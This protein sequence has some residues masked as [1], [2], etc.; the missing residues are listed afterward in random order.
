MFAVFIDFLQ[1]MFFLAFVALQF[2][3]PVG[4]GVG[5]ALAAGY[6]CW[7]MSTGILSGIS[8]AAA[9]A[10]AGG[11]VGAG[12]SAFAIPLGTA[13]DVVISFVFGGALILL[14]IFNRMYYPMP[15]V[16]GFIMESIPVFNII[17][18]WTLMTLRCIALKRREEKKMA[19]PAPATVEVISTP[20][21]FDGI[22]A[23]NDN[24]YEAKV[25]A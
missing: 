16:I 24:L 4:G 6:Y 8:N 22:R 5:G 19:Q 3:T 23:A 9:C 1:G 14:L 18:A 15:T 13:F 2:I 10:A 11:V 17:P 7:K 21:A 12:A 25:A 20:R